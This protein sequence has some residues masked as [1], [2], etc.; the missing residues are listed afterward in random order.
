MHLDLIDA[1]RCPADHEETWLVAAVD[2]LRGRDIV[3]GSLG[4]PVCRARY[5]I[6]GGTADFT[7]GVPL[8]RS[9]ARPPSTDPDEIV[10]LRALLGL[11]DPGGVVAL[12]GPAADVAAALA[13]DVESTLLLVNPPSTALPPGLSAMLVPARLPVAPFT[14]RAA[15]VGGGA[16]VPP[17][18]TS[19]VDALK[20]GGRLVAPAA[21]PLP[22]GLRELAR[23]ARHWVAERDAVRTSPPQPLRRR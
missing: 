2:E 7:A 21:L 18:A 10:R 14:L 5:P 1:L 20:P 22:H 23:D 15:L 8:P 12:V 19:L 13:R 9:D 11:V 6:A 3:H 17:L 4:C 16:L